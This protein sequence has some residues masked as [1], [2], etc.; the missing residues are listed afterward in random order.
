MCYPYT[1]SIKTGVM[2]KQRHIT[3]WP[4]NKT[5]GVESDQWS[6]LC[7]HF[8]QFFKIR[9]SCV[10]VP[11]CSLPLF[12][13]FGLTKDASWPRIAVGWWPFADAFVTLQ[14]DSQLLHHGAERQALPKRKQLKACAETLIK[15]ISNWVI[16]NF[17]HEFEI[18]VT[19]QT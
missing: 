10:G 5:C 12:G 6:D 18:R 16:R 2:R 8:L 19:V 1:N 3:Q 9:G 17:G 15:L 4:T 11:S 13:T 14:G 7:P